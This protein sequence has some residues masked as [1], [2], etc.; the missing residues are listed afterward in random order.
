VP[1]AAGGKTYAHH[2]WQAL[3][4]RI[5]QTHKWGEPFILLSK[6]TSTFRRSSIGPAKIVLE[7]CQALVDQKAKIPSF[8]RLQSG[9]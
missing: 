2:I 5:G 8:H 4:R 3:W 1:S 9:T 7:N 6:T